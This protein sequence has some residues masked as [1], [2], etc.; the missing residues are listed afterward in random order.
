[1]LM[2]NSKIYRYAAWGVL[3]VVLGLILYTF[4]DYGITWDEELQSQYGQAIADYYASW[5]KDLRYTEIFNL[6]LYGGMFDGLAAVVDRYMPFRIYDSRHL[7][8]ALF[9]L[10]GLWGTWR[11]GRLLGGG[12]VGLIALILC[13]TTPMYYGHMFNNPKDIPFAAGIVWTIYFMTRCYGRPKPSVLLK[14]SIILGLTLGVRIGGIMVFAF[15]LAPMGIVVLM[16]WLQ[17]RDAKTARLVIKETFNRAWRVVLPV[18]AVG[19]IVML[20]CWPWAQQHPLMNPVLALGEFSNFPQKVEVL[21]DGTNYMSTDLPWYYV[22]LYFG[23]QLPEFLLFLLAASV[24][25]LPL[26]WRHFMLV[27][28]QGYALILLMIG[29][30]VLYAMLRHPALYDNVRHFLFAVP[31]MC[32]M[33]ALAARNGFVW[34]VAQFLRPMPRRLIA[35]SLYVFAALLLSS[36]IVIMTRLHPYEY[37]YDNIFTGGVQ[38]A[39]GRFSSDYWG[40]S[41]KEAAQQIQDLVAR[42]GGVPPGK[43]YKIAICGPWD[44]AMIYLPPDYEPVV[45]NE[46][47]EFFLATTRWMCQDMRPGKEVI[48]IQRL[49][50]PLAI[51]KD[52]RGGFEHYKGNEN[53]K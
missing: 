48:R 25:L 17:C 43:I 4:L 15:W 2:G 27:Q 30:P 13:A 44:A 40:S 38:G 22:P 7:L 31:L 36:Q 39:Y 49:G 24:V 28:K 11:L 21:F 32:V 19:Y 52:L 47:A 46:P 12:A 51:V 53:E 8:N 16:P 14:L 1:M 45:A 18:A 37:I 29:F 26:T 10:L 50:V 33:A 35:A 42:E 9:G 20:V 5:F 34:C 41:F 6:Y 23:V 3:A